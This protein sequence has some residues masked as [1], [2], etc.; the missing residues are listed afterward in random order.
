MTTTKI[1]KRI[2][3]YMTID[4]ET[5]N[6]FDDPMV[7]DLGLAI[8]DKKGRIYETASY[9]IYDVYA[10][11]AKLMKTAYYVEKLPKYEEALAKGQRKMITIFTAKRIIK[12]LC[13]KYNVKAIIAYNAR[14][15]YK[16]LTNSI[17]YIT[18]SKIR[19]FFP[20][21]IEIWDSMKMAQDTICKQKTYTKFCKNNGFVCGNGTNKKTAEVV[22]RY[23]TKDL[24][25]VEEHQGLDD[26]LIEVAIAAKCFSQHKPMRK[27][28]FK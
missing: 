22:Y 19:Y 25:F 5:A 21:G 18:K 24:D 26:V 23:I 3:Y 20:Y 11:E 10:L 27:F 2:T 28:A 8:H 7:Y 15:D 6:T 13:D 14:F 4:T 1:D 12:E 17:R 9:V 16:A